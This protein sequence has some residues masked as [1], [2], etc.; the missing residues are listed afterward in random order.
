[1]EETIERVGSFF[2][3]WTVYAVR[4]SVLFVYL[5]GWNKTVIIFENAKRYVN[6]HQRR[7]ERCGVYTTS[8]ERVPPAAIVWC[9]VYC[10]RCTSL[11]AESSWFLNCFPCFRLWWWQINIA[12]WRTIVRSF[13]RKCY[14]TLVTAHN[15][16][17]FLRRSYIRVSLIGSP[18]RPLSHS[19]FL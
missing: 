11:F 2:I 14:T 4:A 16:T 9:F 13:G 12:R 7:S 8:V 19:P 17:A 10:Y 5:D 1:M 6:A 15:W 3:S 18:V